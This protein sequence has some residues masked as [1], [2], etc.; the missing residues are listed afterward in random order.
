M[1]KPPTLGD[2]GGQRTDLA[3]IAEKLPDRW[4]LLL[5][6]EAALIRRLNDGVGEV[7]GRSMLLRTGVES[8]EE[9]LVTATV[10]VQSVGL[11]ASTSIKNTPA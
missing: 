1:P 2:R 10:A 3:A 6:S 4:G 11:S 8:N 5:Y 7:A 9:R